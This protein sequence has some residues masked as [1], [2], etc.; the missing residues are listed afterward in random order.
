MGAEGVIVGRGMYGVTAVSDGSY[1]M[2]QEK[3]WSGR[4]DWSGEFSSRWWTWL[5][6][7]ES[8]IFSDR[9]LL[10]CTVLCYKEPTGL[11]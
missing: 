10:L 7:R 9:C 1:L 4:L 11:C 5:S 3:T 8:R 2:G 6:S